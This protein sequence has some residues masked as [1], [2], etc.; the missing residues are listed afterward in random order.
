MLYFKKG[1]RSFN[2]E[3][4]G[5]VGQSAA[6][7]PGSNPGQLVREGPAGRL[8][9]RPLTLT[10]SNFAALSPTD[11]KFSVLKDLNPFLKHSTN[12]RGW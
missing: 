1:I 12:S 11:P 6:K 10:A 7:L 2:T 5:S 9:L 8:F 4:L 3:N